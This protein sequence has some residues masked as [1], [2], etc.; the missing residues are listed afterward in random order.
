MKPYCKV[1]PRPK[2][3]QK[4]SYWTFLQSCWSQRLANVFFFWSE[5]ENSVC[6]IFVTCPPLVTIQFH[7]M[8]KSSFDFLENIFCVPQKK[9]VWDDIS[10][11]WHIFHFWVNYPFKHKVRVNYPFKHKVMSSRGHMMASTQKK[12]L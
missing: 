1:L 4:H 6:V 10:K 12:P 8:E 5:I 7:W 3:F 11:Y 2:F 9:R